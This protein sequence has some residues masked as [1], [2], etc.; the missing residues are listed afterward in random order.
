MFIRTFN[1]YLFAY[2]SNVIT[3]LFLYTTKLVNRRTAHMMVSRYNYRKFAADPTLDPSQEIWPHYIS[4]NIFVCKS[5]Y[6]NIRY[7]YKRANV[8]N[9][10]CDVFI[11]VTEGSRYIPSRQIV[12]SP[13]LRTDEDQRKF[14]YHG[15]D[16]NDTWQ[17]FIKPLKIYFSSKVGFKI[18]FVSSFFKIKLRCREATKG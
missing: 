11:L 2:V 3:M 4:Y 5:N 14:H 7:N 6:E 16:S 17:N 1:D 18:I 12:S 8:I 13:S 10:T 9:V 15:C